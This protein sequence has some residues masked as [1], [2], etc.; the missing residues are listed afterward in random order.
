[1]IDHDNFIY[2][3]DRVG[4][5]FRLVSLNYWAKKLT[6]VQFGCL[7]NWNCILLWLWCSL[8]FYLSVRPFNLLYS[9][10]ISNKTQKVSLCNAQLTCL[11]N[12]RWEKGRKL[13]PNFWSPIVRPT[14]LLHPPLLPDTCRTARNFHTVSNHGAFLQVKPKANSCGADGLKRRWSVLSPNCFSPSL[15]RSSP[16]QVVSHRNP[17]QHHEVW[18]SLQDD[19]ETNSQPQHG[20]PASWHWV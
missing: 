19:H 10:K 8:S 6:H 1:M 18:R 9:Q 20:P 4:D 12:T 13:G 3:H 5:T 15:T 2:F 7:L 11:S 16:N 17:S 14:P